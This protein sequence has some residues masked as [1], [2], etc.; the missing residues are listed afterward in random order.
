MLSKE[1]PRKGCMLLTWES[2]NFAIPST[3]V[4][5]KSSDSLPSN[6]KP[7][8]IKET[9]HMVNKEKEHHL[10]VDGKCITQGLSGENLG[11]VSLLG[12]EGLPS[13]AE[14]RKHIDEVKTKIN[15]IS[16]K[17]NDQQKIDVV[18]QL[19]SLIIDFTPLI[20]DLCRKWLER[21]KKLCNLE[22]KRNKNQDSKNKYQ[23]SVSSIR[24][25]LLRLE[26]LITR[27]LAANK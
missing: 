1:N 11:D 8:V 2:F 12:H 27:Y 13:L 5:S 26:N 14:R 9:L 22:K 19:R 17:I 24:T 15:S 23:L 7:G 3:S 18:Q 10:A 25:Y 4:L 6:M 20:S 21:R 16:S